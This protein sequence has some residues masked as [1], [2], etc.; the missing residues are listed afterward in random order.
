MLQIKK[1]REK[2]KTLDFQTKNRKFLLFYFLE[3]SQGGG[4]AGKGTYC[5]TSLP[6]FSSSDPHN[7]RKYQ[8]CKLSSDLHMCTV[9]ASFP[10]IS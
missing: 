5:Q 2:E 7:G 1:K 8:F 6:E 9:H 10:K 3:F 4:L